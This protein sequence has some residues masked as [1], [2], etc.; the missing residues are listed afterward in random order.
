MPLSTGRL[1]S[2]EMHGTQTLP[3]QV[4]EKSNSVCQTTLSRM[5]SRLGYLKRSFSLLFFSL[6]VPL[7]WYERPSDFV[8]S[9]PVTAPAASSA[10]PLTL[11]I[12]PSFLSCPLLFLPTR[13]SFLCLALLRPQAPEEPGW[14]LSSHLRCRSG[15]LRFPDHPSGSSVALLL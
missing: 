7:R 1:A 4:S 8:A 5:A 6:A 11:S 2:A 3:E 15:E 10:R 12:A 13:L 14:Q 9:F